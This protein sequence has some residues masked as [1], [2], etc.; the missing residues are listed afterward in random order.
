MVVISRYSWWL[1]SNTQ[2]FRLLT[3]SVI[4]IWIR[5]YCL[6]SE[7]YKTMALETQEQ[8]NK[9]A[10]NYFSYLNRHIFSWHIEKGTTLTTSRRI[11]KCPNPGRGVLTNSPHRDR[12]DD[13]CPSHKPSLFS[14][15]GLVLL[16]QKKNSKIGRLR[17]GKIRKF[18]VLKISVHPHRSIDSSFTA[19]AQCGV[20]VD[21]IYT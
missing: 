13:K 11:D 10:Q 14:Q 16:N 19:T 18:S 8:A 6:S 7:L 21:N 3:N 5:S 9:T 4:N 17:D 12:Q 20:V 1:I 2:H 15:T